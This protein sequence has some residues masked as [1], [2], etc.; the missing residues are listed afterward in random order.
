M[1]K[2][3]EKITDFLIYSAMVKYWADGKLNS[4]LI[5]KKDLAWCSTRSVDPDAGMGDKFR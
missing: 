2:V 1:L 3:S 5:K 4:N